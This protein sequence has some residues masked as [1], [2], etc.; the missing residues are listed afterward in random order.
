L[1][2]AE[3]L[4]ERKAQLRLRMRALRDAV[5]PG[6]RERMAAAVE[7]RLVAVPAVAAARGVL[8]FVSFG[9]EIPTGG[10]RPR[11]HREGRRVFL[12]YLAAGDLQVAEVQ[13]D[14]VLVP[15]TYGPREPPPEQRSPASQAPGERAFD[16]VVVP[17]LAFDR[18]GYRLG[19][20]G[21]HYDRLLSV[22]GGATASVGI[23]YHFQV[24]AAVPH[25]PFDRRLDFVVTDR[26]TIA[27]R[28]DP[29]G[30]SPDPMRPDAG[31]SHG[32]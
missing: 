26:E 16:V 14:D 21:G 1:G 31:E 29:A 17:G 32:G 8:L 19:F 12:P 15:S 25:G 22:L 18:E 23:G 28:A 24:L 3:D 2:A 11:F 5:P 27:T 13:A 9:S 7:E 20:G 4:D 30:A 10:L 6:E